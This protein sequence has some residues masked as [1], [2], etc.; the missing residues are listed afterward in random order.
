MHKVVVQQECGCFIRS[1]L[2]NNLE[3]S[4]KDEALSKAIQMRNQMNL[5]FCKKHDFDLVEYGENFVISFREEN[6]SS[7][8]GN[9]CCG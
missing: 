1:D 8:C 3:Y 2:K 4:S 9:G 6:P 5:D 7:C